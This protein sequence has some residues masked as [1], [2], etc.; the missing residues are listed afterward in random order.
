MQRDSMRYRMLLR[1]RDLVRLAWQSGPSVP[2]LSNTP[3]A[4]FPPGQP[5]DL[6]A[7]CFQAVWETIPEEKRRT[8]PARPYVANNFGALLD[9]L[10]KPIA[11]EIRVR[12]GSVGSDL[13]DLALLV[14]F[15]AVIATD[16]GDVIRLI[17]CVTGDPFA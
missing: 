12:L 6:A 15:N 2:D 11:D 14:L 4:L 10:I 3:D 1:V 7:A 13:E 16:E 5:M 9:H 17:D 8:E